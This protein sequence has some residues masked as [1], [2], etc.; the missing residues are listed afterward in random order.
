MKTLDHSWIN[1]NSN[2]QSWLLLLPWPLLLPSPQSPLS[3]NLPPLPPTAPGDNSE[4]RQEVKKH[5]S[6]L[7]S[8]D[9]D[10]PPHSSQTTVCH[11][12]QLSLLPIHLHE[13]PQSLGN[14]QYLS[15]NQ[16]LSTCRSHDHLP[17]LPSILYL[18]SILPTYNIKHRL[19]SK[20]PWHLRPLQMGSWGDS[21]VQRIN[22]RQ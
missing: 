20:Q 18:T 21:Y 19:R 13:P 11:A 17:S 4:S 2:L 7:P 1:T 16:S 9:R 15:H 10:L 8:T 14:D 3:D 12:P 5:M 22:A 6:P